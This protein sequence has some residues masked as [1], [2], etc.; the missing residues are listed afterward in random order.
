[1]RNVIRE[2]LEYSDKEKEEL[3]NNAIIVF[4]TNVLLNLYRYSQKTRDIL[5]DAMEQFKTRLWMPNHVAHEFMKNRS[6]VI[7]ET[8]KNYEELHKQANQFISSCSEMLRISK[9]DK[10]LVKLKDYIESWIES[11]KENNLLVIDV[12]IDPILDKILDLFEGKVGDGFDEEKKKL[13]NDEANK[14]FAD[15]IPPGYMDAEKKSGLNDNNA[16]GDFVI[17]KEILLFSKQKGKDIIYV[18]HDQK[19]DWWNRKHGK[20]LGPRI[21]LRKEFFEVTNNRFHMYTMNNFISQVEK[22]KGQEIDQS[23]IE[24]MKSINLSSVQMPI[25]IEEDSDEIILND[26]SSIKLKM[27]TIKNKIE[28][29]QIKNTKRERVIYELENKYSSKN[30]PDD[31]FYKLTNTRNNLYKDEEEIYRLI[32]KMNELEIKMFNTYKKGFFG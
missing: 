17:W 11:N 1:M 32:E 26:I 28:K 6:E 23:V 15:K 27:K 7:F 3:W 29:L 22:N 25:K 24:E 2:Y 31:V 30:M 14:R 4:D 13:I 16:F 19:E 12:L 20:T 8:I 5:L 21:E 9:D 18:T 10:E